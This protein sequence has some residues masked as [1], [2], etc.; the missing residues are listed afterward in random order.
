M[1]YKGPVNNLIGILFYFPAWLWFLKTLVMLYI[2]N[3][4]YN[5]LP[6]KII[7]GYFFILCLLIYPFATNFYWFI[8][9]LLNPETNFPHWGIT[10]FF[11]MY[12]IVYYLLPQYL[13][14]MINVRVCIILILIGFIIN[15]F[16]V[17]VY[18]N[19]F[20]AIQDNGN[21]LFPTFGTLLITIGIWKVFKN[22]EGSLIFTKTI[23]RLI[24]FFCD[25][26]LGIYIFHLPI[27][28]AFKYLIVEPVNFLSGIAI[29]VVILILSTLISSTIK[30]SKLGSFLLSL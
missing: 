30:L 6:N 25:N 18:S 15:F 19:F 9:V 26:T 3:Y 24:T 2:F 21:A 12:S 23:K 22:Y 20:K 16:V 7:W 14:Q 11:T 27:I 4:I 1:F 29:C 13:S 28:F 10:G 5:H 17:Y 8:R